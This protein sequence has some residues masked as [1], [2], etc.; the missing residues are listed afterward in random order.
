MFKFL[1]KAAG[2]VTVTVL[3]LKLGEAVSR[4]ICGKQHSI[5][6]IGKP[7]E[8]GSVGMIGN[9]KNASS[10]GIIGGADGPTAIFIAGRANPQAVSNVFSRLAHVVRKRWNQLW[11]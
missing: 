9:L 10:I 4:R 2:M 5:K 6:I 1:C 8:A 7:K 3:I 11:D